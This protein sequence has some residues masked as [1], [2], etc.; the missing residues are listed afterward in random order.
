MFLKKVVEKKLQN[1]NL[2]MWIKKKVGKLL[3]NIEIL[4]RK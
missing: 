3:L 1:S 2:E 4:A